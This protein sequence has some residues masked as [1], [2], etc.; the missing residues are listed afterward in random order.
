MIWRRLFG[1]D[2]IKPEVHLRRRQTGGQTDRETETGGES[3]AVAVV[4]A[5]VVVAASKVCSV[6]YWN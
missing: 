6:M 2:N 1:G 5:V 4:F 3:V